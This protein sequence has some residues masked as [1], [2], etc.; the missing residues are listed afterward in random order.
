MSLYVLVIESSCCSNYNE[1]PTSNGLDTSFNVA[2]TDGGVTENTTSPAPDPL[3]L[4][5]AQGPTA[6]VTEVGGL[7]PE[8]SEVPRHQHS[9]FKD[10]DGNKSGSHSS[11]HFLQGQGQGQGQGRVLTPGHPLPYHIR[12]K[13]V[14]MAATGVR[15]I[16]AIS[17]E[18][19]VSHSCVAKILARYQETGSLLPEKPGPKFVATPEME[20]KRLHSFDNPLQGWGSLNQWGRAFTHGRPLPTHV[21]LRIVE[22]AATGARPCVISR[23]LRVSHSCVSRIIARYQETGRLLPKKPGPG[24]KVR[25]AASEM[26]SKIKEHKRDRPDILNMGIREQLISEELSN[27]SPISR[28]LHGAGDGDTEPNVKAYSQV[29]PGL[30]SD[31]NLVDDSSRPTLRPRKTTQRFG[32]VTTPCLSSSDSDSDQEWRP[33]GKMPSWRPRLPF[34]RRRRRGAEG[35]GSGTAC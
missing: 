6:R 3:Q 12:L 10:L 33:E 9:A 27:V 14:E 16:R 26:Q 15:P 20:N 31:G 28:V 2:D 34:P 24:T 23:Q 35:R 11:D 1:L 21:R 25:A 17:R 29:K 22:M 5:A 32:G 4:P 30:S 18:L 7:P 19:G 8:G 13:I